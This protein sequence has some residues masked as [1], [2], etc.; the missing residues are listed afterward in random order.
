MCCIRAYRCGASGRR[1]PP[2]PLD[3][4]EPPSSAAA[5]A[6]AATQPSVPCRAHPPPV[7]HPTPH[8]CRNTQA[9][10]NRTRSMAPQ[11][12]RQS[13]A[14]RGA[15]CTWRSEG[16]GEAAE[17]GPCW[18]PEAPPC[19]A[20]LRSASGLIVCVPRLFVPAVCC[21]ATH[22]PMRPTPL[23]TTGDERGSKRRRQA[24]G[25]AAPEGGKA[26][27]RVRGCLLQPYTLCI[28]SRAA[29]CRLRVSSSLGAVAA[30]HPLRCSPGPHLLLNPGYLRLF[31]VAGQHWQQHG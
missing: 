24:D 2:T 11:Q 28:G 27:T 17:V 22:P 1:A 14:A 29:R 26:D 3:P 16:E 12:G 13:G 6:A 21:P 4:L 31:P 25:I 9:G 8:W 30:F 10:S 5:A 18:L 15:V 19:L 23:A 7:P 20:R